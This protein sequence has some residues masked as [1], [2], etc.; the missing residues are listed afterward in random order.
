M[1]W[2]ITTYVERKRKEE[3][4]EKEIQCQQKVGE[5]EE[6]NSRGI[7][8]SWARE[9]FVKTKQW[10]QEMK[11]KWMKRTESTMWKSKTNLCEPLSDD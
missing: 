5:E 3:A 6:E 2:K 7:R 1:V 10:P 11:I 4:T 9:M 8:K